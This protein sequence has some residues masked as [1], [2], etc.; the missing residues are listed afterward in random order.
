VKPKSKSKKIF[1]IVTGV[2]IFLTLPSILFFGFV[3][4]KYNEELP[5]GIQ[6]EKADALAYKML[7]AL[8][9]E[10]YKNTNYIEWTFKKRHH[11]NGKKMKTS[12]KCFGKNIA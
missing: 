5:I 6:G 4:F 1:K 9:Y 8:D 2:I 12:A 10:A 11:L 3:F 7:E